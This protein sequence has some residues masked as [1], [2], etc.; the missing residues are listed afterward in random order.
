[1]VGGVVHKFM[2]YV[3][4]VLL[5]VFQPSRSIPCLL[6]II[7]FLDIFWL[8]G[9][10]IRFNFDSYHDLWF[11]IRFKDDIGSFRTI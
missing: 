9:V 11:S 10:M 8:I 5:F 2:L 3:D 1:M 4:N 7:D 6:G